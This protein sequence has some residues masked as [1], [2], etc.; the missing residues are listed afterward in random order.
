V[1]P[2]HRLFGLILEHYFRG[3]AWE[4]LVELDL[5]RKVQKLDIVVVR[6]R[7]GPEPPQLPDGLGPL[8]DHNLITFKS[9]CSA[10]MRFASIT[11]RTTS[12]LRSRRSARS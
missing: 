9:T 8:A 5:S 6:R 4:V 7:A 2:W 12:W 3:S 10:A 1:I 11:R